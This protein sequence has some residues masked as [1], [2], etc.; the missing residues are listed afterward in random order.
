MKNRENV[1]FLHASNSDDKG[2]KVTL[3]DTLC[4][5]EKGVNYPSNHCHR[6]TLLH[7]ELT[8]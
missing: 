4:V 2:K 5:I 3:F 7:F 6:L 1:V 8:F